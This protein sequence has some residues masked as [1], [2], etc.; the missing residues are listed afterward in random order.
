M[1]RPKSKNS[2]LNNAKKNKNDEFY[3]RLVDIE[4]E[5]RHYKEQF[6]N[7]VI[8]CNC[9]D[10]FE[11]NFFKYFALKFNELK[12]KKL[13]CT[14]YDGSKITGTQLSLFDF[15]PEQDIISRKTAYKIEINEVLDSTADISTLLKDSKNKLT[16]LKGNGDF[17]SE[18]CLKILEKSDIVVT[19]PP[20]SLARKFISTLF[21]Y[22]KKFLI[23]GNKN[24]VVCKEIFPLI[25]ENKM[26]L[27]YNVSNGSISFIDV[28]NNNQIKSVPAY[29]YTNL[30]VK[31][32]HDYL[33]LYEHYRPE[34]YPKYANYNAIDVSRT[35]EIPMDYDGIM[36]VP[37]TFLG[38]YNPEQFEIIG[39]S[40]EL[41]TPIKQI[42]KPDD[43]YQL[44][45]NSFYIR[46]GPNTLQRLYSRIAIKKKSERP[47]EEK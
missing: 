15:M 33:T 29:R 32:R 40:L 12:L 6:K 24:T 39:T 46:T 7:K 8:L 42:A 35:C 19:N 11:S 37:I 45:G 13:I 9:D 16:K 10:P 22:D 18:E 27:G 4:N 26:W 43:K 44:G 23:I 3:T 14:C 21:D 20:F 38:K 31:I 17:A 36:G 41:A 2:N 25:K 34:K 30:D 47:S 1:A 28:G 5:L